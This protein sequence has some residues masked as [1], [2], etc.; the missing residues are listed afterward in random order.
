MYKNQNSIW[1]NI[2]NLRY[3]FITLLATN[4]P[5]NN[6]K[7]AKNVQSQHGKQNRNEN[8]RVNRILEASKQVDESDVS[9]RMEGGE[10]GFV[11]QSSQGIR[12][13]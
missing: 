5:I 13:R 1:L 4:T 6:T 7:K 11:L 2:V 8:D 10:S 9:S 3:A 12:M